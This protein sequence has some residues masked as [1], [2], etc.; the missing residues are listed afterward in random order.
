M[1][2]RSGKKTK[3]GQPQGC[4]KGSRT[5]E[6]KRHIITG[7]IWV[8]LKEGREKSHKKKGKKIKSRGE[9]GG[10]HEINRVRALGSTPYTCVYY[11]AYGKG[12]EREKKGVIFAK[13]GGRSYKI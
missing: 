11:G 1:G 5:H 4:K 12:E 3:S 7:T 9:K 10:R 2:S 13:G 8:G 6:K